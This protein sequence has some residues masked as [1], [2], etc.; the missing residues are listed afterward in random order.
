M[1]LSPE[2]SAPG[3]SDLLERIDALRVRGGDVLLFHER[4]LYSMTD[5]VNR[6]T[7]EHVR[8]VV[9]LSLL[10]RVFE[11]RYS[12]LPGS[13]LEALSRLLTQNVRIYAYPM[14]SK[15]LEQS[16]Q[17]ISATGWEWTDTRGWVSADQLRLAPPLGHLY[18]YLLTSNFL[19]PMRTPS[20]LTA[21]A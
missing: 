7:K 4:E 15:D 8:F 20:E 13:M 14:S 5:L 18:E 16:L 19:V 3:I 11:Y 21:R 1:A 2:A 12:K 6:Y 9:G 10:I 17:S